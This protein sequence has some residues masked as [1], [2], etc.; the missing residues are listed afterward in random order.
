MTEE[1]PKITSS[2]GRP[3]TAETSSP[4]VAAHSIE[5]VPQEITRAKAEFFLP[6][7]MERTL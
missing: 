7:R 2:G 6:P 3:K 1:F 4:L 5:H